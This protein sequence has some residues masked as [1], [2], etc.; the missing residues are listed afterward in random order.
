M[1]QS[2]LI[3]A[4]QNKTENHSHESSCVCYSVVERSSYDWNWPGQRIVLD[5]GWRG[6]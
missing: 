2:S 4:K 1:K 3:V 5:P 6:A